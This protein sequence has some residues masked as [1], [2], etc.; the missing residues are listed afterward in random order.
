MGGTFDHHVLTVSPVTSLSPD[1]RCRTREAGGLRAAAGARSG[2]VPD[3]QERRPA[4]VL[5][6][7]PRALAGT[8][9]APDASG[10]MDGDRA[11][12][13]LS[14]PSPMWPVPLLLLVLSVPPANKGRTGSRVGGGQVPQRLPGTWTG[15]M[16]WVAPIITEDLL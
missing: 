6:S 8:P 7:A 5:C 13:R 16:E 4:A 2:R 14:L 12:S 3:Q 15:A 1:G 11:H 10:T 9:W